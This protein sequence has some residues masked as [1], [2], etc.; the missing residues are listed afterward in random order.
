MYLTTIR[1][2]NG[3][4]LTQRGAPGSRFGHGAAHRVGAGGNAFGIGG[5]GGCRHSLYLSFVVF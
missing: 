3:L 2:R 4:I 1:V 5:T